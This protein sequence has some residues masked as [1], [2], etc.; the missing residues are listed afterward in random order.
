M[1]G[2]EY[3][4]FSQNEHYG[5]ENFSEWFARRNNDHVP[6][7]QNENTGKYQGTSN[8]SWQDSYFQ[9]DYT[10]HDNM[11]QEWGASYSSDWGTPD[12]E[13]SFTSNND[14]W[15]EDFRG[16]DESN[17]GMRYDRRG[18]GRGFYGRRGEGGKRRMGQGRFPQRPYG[19]RSRGRNSQRTMPE[20]LIERGTGMTEQRPESVHDLEEMGQHSQGDGAQQD[21]GQS[22]RVEGGQTSK[23]GTSNNV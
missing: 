11:N 19:S 20:S 12:E 22:N 2:S 9:S 21:Q 3:N 16:Y 14:M 4:C 10:G 7:E 15:T 6:Y 5:N 13:F 1:S 17:R 23:T 8:N 18:G